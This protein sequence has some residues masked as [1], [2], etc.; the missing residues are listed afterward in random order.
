MQLTKNFSKKE[1]ECKCGC[2]KCDMDLELLDA[3]QALRDRLGFPLSITSGFRCEEHNKKVG[4]ARASKH[5]KG[6]AV[7]ISIMTPP[8]RN[9]QHNLKAL[10]KE[11]LKD[12]R[13]NGIGVANS[14]LHLDIREEPALWSY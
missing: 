12:D 7:D 11:A 3:L 5:L 9:N 13:I 10:L 1:L 6:Q 8:F 14:F 2:G 4:G